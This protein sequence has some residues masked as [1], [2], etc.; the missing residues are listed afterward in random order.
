MISFFL[1][2]PPIS[3]MNL[4]KNPMT[5]DICCL[6]RVIETDYFRKNHFPISNFNGDVK[7]SNSDL[8]VTKERTEVMNSPQQCGVVM[9]K[10]CAGCI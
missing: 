1:D 7:N 5:N 10:R 2:F 3:Y 4:C 8:T 9:M 6:V